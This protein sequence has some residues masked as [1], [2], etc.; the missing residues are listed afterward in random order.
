MAGKKATPAY[1]TPFKA[2]ANDPQWFMEGAVTP[3]IPNA[4]AMRGYL[5]NAPYLQETLSDPATIRMEI[6]KLAT[7]GDP[8]NPETDYRIRLLEKALQDIY[9]VAPSGR[10]VLPGPATPSSAPGAVTPRQR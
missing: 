5:R 2:G 7:E 10:E 1:A 8:N 9:N 4:G 3:A 6:Y